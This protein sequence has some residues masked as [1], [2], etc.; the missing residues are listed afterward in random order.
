MK[1]FSRVAPCLALL[2]ALGSAPTLA[3]ETAS[4]L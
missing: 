3:A 2:T 1:N 4:R